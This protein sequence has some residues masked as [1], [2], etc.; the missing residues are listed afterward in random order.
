[1]PSVAKTCTTWVR[2]YPWSM[3]RSC[4]DSGSSCVCSVCPAVWVIGEAPLL[5]DCSST[6]RSR[7]STASCIP[8]TADEK[9]FS[10]D[11]LAEREAGDVLAAVDQLQNELAAAA[12]PLL[13][14][15]PGVAV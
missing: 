2:K 3:R 9:D 11:I 13:V 7:Q 5:S 15:L 8:H 12:G 4:W 6:V 14:G 1:M 10:R